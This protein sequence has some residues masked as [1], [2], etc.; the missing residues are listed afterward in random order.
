MAAVCH[1]AIRGDD[2]APGIIKFT[3]RYRSVRVGTIPAYGIYCGCS[4]KNVYR[5]VVDVYQHGFS[6]GVSV[7]ESLPWGVLPQNAVMESLADN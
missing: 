7:M 2:V 4:G 3:L 5:C 1:R 6:F